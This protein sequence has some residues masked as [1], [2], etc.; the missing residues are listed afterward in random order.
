[1]CGRYGVEHTGQQLAL[2]FNLMQPLPNFEPA[3]ELCPTDTVPTVVA[4]ED[5]RHL[6]LQRWWLVPSWWQ[7]EL[8]AL[9]TLFNARAESLTEKPIFRGA[10]QSRRCLV[11][12]SYFYEWTKTPRGKLKNRIERAD[13]APLAFAGLWE[14]WRP[15]EGDPLRSCTIITTSPNHVMEPIHTRM[16]VI[17]GE[18]EWDEWLSPATRAADLLHLLQPCPDDWLKTHLTDPPAPTLF[19]EMWE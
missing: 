7:K 1:M 16:P 6:D 17:L 15:P 12:A 13:G 8:K 11:P 18:D 14:E 3:A 10:L 4:R 9:P 19:D 2:Y 5:G